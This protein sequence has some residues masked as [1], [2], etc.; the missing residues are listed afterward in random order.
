[1]DLN[2]EAQQRLPIAEVGRHLKIKFPYILGDVTVVAVQNI[3][4][5]EFKD[6]AAYIGVTEH[7]V[8]AIVRYGGKLLPEQAVAFF[9]RFPIEK[10]RP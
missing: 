8:D 7:G 5:G 9:P 3:F 6:W 4:D 1:M 2:A 10:Y